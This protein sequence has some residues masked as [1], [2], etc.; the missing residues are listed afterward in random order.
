MTA[1]NLLGMMETFCFL[2]WVE[3]RHGCLYL[4]ELIDW[5]EEWGRVSCN[6]LFLHSLPPTPR[7]PYILLILTFQYWTRRMGPW[8]TVDKTEGTKPVRMEGKGRDTK[9][10]EQLGWVYDG[11]AF[12][13]CRTGFSGHGTGHWGV[14]LMSHLTEGRS[15]WVAEYLCFR[16][17]TPWI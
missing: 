15:T 7:N 5:R 12:T 2:I 3:V 16:N 6:E 9:Y 13:A 14:F 11:A 17:Q 10:W 8:G 1:G 4:T